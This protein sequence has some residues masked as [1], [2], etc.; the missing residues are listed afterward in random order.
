[1]EA[2]VGEKLSN[3]EKEDCGTSNMASDD[4]PGGCAGLA[5]PVDVED[6]ETWATDSVTG[7]LN[8]GDE[9]DACAHVETTLEHGLCVETDFSGPGGAEM[10]ITDV[11][12]QFS[13]CL[14]VCV[15]SFFGEPPTLSDVAGPHCV[16][17]S[18]SVVLCM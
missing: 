15:S 12:V 7:A 2:E 8:L 6:F 13:P 3:V 17:A 9:A 4:R 18:G 14:A 5:G 11:L 1:M 10:S 16:I